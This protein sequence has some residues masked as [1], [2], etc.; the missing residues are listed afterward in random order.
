MIPVERVLSVLQPEAPT[1]TPDLQLLSPFGLRVEIGYEGHLEKAVLELVYALKR[2]LVL[3]EPRL[4]LQRKPMLML[5]AFPFGREAFAVFRDIPVDL[6]CGVRH[7]DYPF[8]L[9]TFLPSSNEKN[10]AS[11]SHSHWISASRCL[12]IGFPSALSTN[13]MVFFSR[14]A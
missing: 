3:I 4:F 2:P 5:L 10:S 6:L 1:R 13:A 11:Q 12:T 14:F 7:P 8:L 9:V